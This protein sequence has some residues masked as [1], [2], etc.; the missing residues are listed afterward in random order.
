MPFLRINTWSDK[1]RHTKDGY[2]LN[3]ILR[4]KYRKGDFTEVDRD[5][6]RFVIDMEPREY[7]REQVIA[8]IKEGDKYE[9]E[10]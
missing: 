6:L 4:S 1:R 7:E 2:A 3:R 8:A 5:V 9:A 10:Q